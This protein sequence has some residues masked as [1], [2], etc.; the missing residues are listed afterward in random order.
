[1]T[2]AG[3]H[4]QSRRLRW[5]RHAIAGATIS[6]L[7]N[8]VSAQEQ[9]IER[10]YVDSVVV[11]G[12]TRVAPA[13]VRIQGGIHAGDSIDYRDI[14]RA[15]HRLWRSGEYNDV[16]IDA[17][18]SPEANGITLAIVI[19]EHLLLNAIDFEGLEHVDGERIAD[20][21]GLALGEP[22]RPAAIAE[23]IA[24]LR[25]ELTAEG[26][27]PVVTHRIERA[28]ERAT[29]A[30]LV[31]EVSEGQRV[32]IAEVMFEGNTAFD[33]E[34]LR[35][36]L[37]TREEGFFW[38]R[39]GR[40]DPAVLRDDVRQKL[41]DFYGQA[42]Y[43]DFAVTADTIIVDPQSGKAR[44]VVTL[45]E[46]AQYVL[47]EFDV[48]GNRRYSFDELSRYYRPGEQGLLAALGI[49][50]GRTAT[51]DRPVFDATAFREATAEVRRLYSN[52]GYMYAQVQ[53][54]IERTEADGA[55]AVR[56]RWQIEEGNPAY[57]NQVAIIGNT[58]THEQVIRERISLL[59]GDVYSEDRLIQSYRS[60]QSLGFFRSPM[61]MPRMEPTEEGDVNITFEVEEQQTGSINFGASMGGSSIGIAGFVGY[62][63][64]NLF[65]RAKS[66]R[67]NLEFGT[68][69]NN[70]E[71]SYTDPAILESRWSGSFSLFSSTDRYYD[72]GEGERRRTGVGLRL[73]YPFPLD[74]RWTR[75]YAG[76][77][78]AETAYEPVDGSTGTIFDQPDALQST[79][80]AGLV[81]N[82]LDHPMFPTAG[83]RYSLD[84]EF[85]GGILGGD[86]QFQKYEL[87][88]STYIPLGAIGGQEP[89]SRPIRF[90]LGL[91]ADAGVLGGDPTRFPF[92]RF[93][94][95]GVQFGKP[96][97]GYDETTIT[98]D[99]FVDGDDDSVE[100][101]SRFG[102]AYLRLSGEYAMRF[103]DNL[104]V[105]LFYD[106]G[107]VWDEPTEVDPTR[108]F[109][110]A[111]VGLM[112][113]TPFGPIGLDYAY[114]F[115]RDIPGWQLHF[116]FGQSF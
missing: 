12:A 111:G 11:E 30:R 89:G 82:T 57:I 74:P 42:G 83:S 93:W 2:V 95:G 8:P 71:A 47:D 46:G 112:I 81:R 4:R 33:D 7:A 96:L 84:M 88:T 36:V 75:V 94:M 1:M 87:A 85:N 102:D 31:F 65:G 38:F 63:Q 24:M 115:D 116:K 79:V 6:L 106:G 35:S 55:A 80:S 50:G 15:M 44:L 19:E 97:R 92:E 23:A 29:V 41:P 109:R 86:G 54:V 39:T 21:V 101:T 78:I 98:P 107:G 49:G 20:T 16:R 14:Q 22:A 28:E 58:V 110:G 108:L 59:P 66:G 9:T 34:Q 104:S 114:G 73:G 67:L 43:I 32:A 48:E 72:F 45:T 5:T 53:S 18:D 100:L 60:I 25:D 99:G 62:T 77:S 10:V 105:A 51:G 26:F 40:Y 13:E 52:S 69:T 27:V 64:P 68:T 17:R 91:T 3:L 56:A 70:L 113:V 61:P 103:N 90:T 37:D 76:Y